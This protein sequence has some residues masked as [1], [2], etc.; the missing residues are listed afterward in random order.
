MSL[1]IS[2]NAE[3]LLTKW[4][5]FRVSFCIL[6]TAVTTNHSM[7]WTWNCRRLIFSQ[8][9]VIVM[10]LEFYL[11]TTWRSGL[12]RWYVAL[13]WCHKGMTRSISCSY[14]D[15]SHKCG[16]AANLANLREAAIYGGTDAKYAST[17]QLHLATKPNTG[18]CSVPMSVRPVAAGRPFTFRN[19]H[20]PNCIAGVSPRIISLSSGKKGM[21]K[22][23][24]GFDRWISFKHQCSEI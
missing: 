15:F 12:W 13:Q 19:R 22:F 3:I 18:G 9:N 10:K 16:I 5:N 24:S 20:W 2:W 23:W 8:C 11:R 4:I 7:T 21:Q 17:P 14:H 6:L 1:M